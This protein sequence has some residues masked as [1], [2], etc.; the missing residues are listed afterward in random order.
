MGD[1]AMEYLDDLA[2]GAPD[3]LDAYEFTGVEVG[4]TVAAAM[5]ADPRVEITGAEKGEFGL[6]FGTMVLDFKITG[7]G[8]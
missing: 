1:D 5:R 7:C 4:D 2:G 6:D 8:G 3:L